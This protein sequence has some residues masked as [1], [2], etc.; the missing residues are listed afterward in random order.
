MFY[1]I[2][3]YGIINNH[4]NMDRNMY[5]GIIS[6]KKKWNDYTCFKMVQIWK[7]CPKWEMLAAKV[8]DQMIGFNCNG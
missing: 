5:R 8:K 3:H 6:N 1:I 2:T 7:Y 4:W